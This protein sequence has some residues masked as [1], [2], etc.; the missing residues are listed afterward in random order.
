MIINRIIDRM[1]SKLDKHGIWVANS[2]DSS[3]TNDVWNRIY[4]FNTQDLDRLHK[5][6]ER[7]KM[8]DLLFYVNP[9]LQDRDDYVYLEI[10]CGPSFLGMYLLQNT[11]ICFIGVD[12][13]YEALLILKKYFEQNKIDK[14]RYL[15]LYSDIRKMPIKNDC[16]DF[17]YG[18]GVIEHVPN[19]TDVLKEV[20]R[21][22]KNTGISFNSVPAFNFFWLTRSIMS[23]PNIPI[24]RNIF[25]FIHISIL[26]EKIWQK[27]Y[28]Y[29]L[30]FTQNKLISLHKS[31]EF[32][33]IKTGVFSFHPNRDKL[34][35]IFLYRLFYFISKNSL[36][37]PF[38]FVRGEK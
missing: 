25:E 19:T 26:K 21:V 35:N 15:L 29:E 1:Q 28:G 11:N 34:K 36:S 9:E 10:G 6:F 16:I 7:D 14:E 2:V 38:Y 32:K 37:C 33:N 13:N 4:N 5:D 24:I 18:G 8:K 17:V 30:C 31:V 23:V 12:F 3:K 20:Y 27:F 22:L